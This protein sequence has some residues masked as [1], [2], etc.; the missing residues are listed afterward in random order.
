M[1]Y[2]LNKLNEDKSQRKGSKKTPLPNK[3]KIL[4]TINQKG[5]E[6]N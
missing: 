4:S 6:L 5:H 2:P 1:I 3:N